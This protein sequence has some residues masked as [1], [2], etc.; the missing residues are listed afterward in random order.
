M[1]PGRQMRRARITSFVPALAVL[2]CGT[3]AVSVVQAA[4][5]LVGV[6][7]G[8][9]I[10]D[11]TAFYTA[12]HLVWDGAG[13]SLYDASAQEAMQRRLFGPVG[14]PFGFTQPA[15]VAA[16]MAPLAA[17]SFRAS[18]WAWMA[19]N[20]AMEGTLLAALWRALGERPPWQRAAVLGLA[21]AS[22][23]AVAV[24]LN[25]QLDFFVLAASPCSGGDG[26]GPPAPS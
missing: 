22:P 25:G 20:I 5:V 10:S 7:R 17:F 3:L 12:A 11:W 23:L 18:Y 6:A 24:V 19:V 21:A 4:I 2:A 9:I 1:P 26:P 13:R 15:F 16:A 14:E 8:E